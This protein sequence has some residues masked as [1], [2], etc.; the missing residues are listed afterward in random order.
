[1]IRVH[2]SSKN[3]ELAYCWQR[4]SWRHRVTCYTKMYLTSG[5]YRI[6][7]LVFATARTRRTIEYL[8]WLFN[9]YFI[10]LVRTCF[11]LFTTIRDTATFK[12]HIQLIFFSS[13]ANIDAPYQRVS[14]RLYSSEST[15]VLFE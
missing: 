11:I 6:A 10:Y 3:G 1:M 4:E 15:A 12:L 5:I 14:I 2:F 7:Y 8:L 13:K 9:P